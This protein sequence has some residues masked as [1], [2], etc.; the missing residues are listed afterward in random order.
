LDLDDASEAEL[1][2]CGALEICKLSEE[3]YELF[4]VFSA[5][6]NAW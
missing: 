1:R 5:K 4:G 2:H 6:R 3:R